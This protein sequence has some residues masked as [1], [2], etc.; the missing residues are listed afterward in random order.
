MLREYCRNSAGTLWKYC[1]NAQEYRSNT[2]GYFMNATGI[3]LK[4]GGTLWQYWRETAVI[5]Q[6]FFFL[7]ICWALAEK[8]GEVTGFRAQ[9]VIFACVPIKTPKTY[10][11]L[12]IFSTQDSQSQTWILALV[13]E[14]ELSNAGP[15]HNKSFGPTN[16]SIQ[17]CLTMPG[18]RRTSLITPLSHPTEGFV[19]K[20]Q[21]QHRFFWQWGM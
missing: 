13:V 17:K 20:A 9:C 14:S 11:Q 8:H 15:A 3:L 6:D 16:A 19:P 10:L 12:G 21:Y 4:Y 18:A 7:P 1:W 5:L 2:A